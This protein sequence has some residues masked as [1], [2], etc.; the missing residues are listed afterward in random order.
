MQQLAS[1]TT[2]GGVPLLLVIALIGTGA[3]LFGHFV[4]RSNAKLQAA[5][6]EKTARLAN[7]Q[8]RENAVLSARLSANVKL[9]DMRQVW[10]NELRNEMTRFF[11]MCNEKRNAPAD[12][13]AGKLHESGTKIELSMNPSD[14]DYNELRSAMFAIYSE[15]PA[16]TTAETLDD[17]YVTVCQKILKREWDVLKGDIRDALLINAAPGSDPKSQ[18]GPWY[19]RS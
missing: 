10:I 17:R 7:E 6:G 18:I 1:E 8:S 5:I 9:A 15:V 3:A 16:D 19:R 12:V 14:S 13:K 4:I 2:T 11:A